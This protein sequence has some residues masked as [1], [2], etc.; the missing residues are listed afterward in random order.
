VPDTGAG[1]SATNRPVFALDLTDLASPASPPNVGLCCRSNPGIP[2][3]LVTQRVR[4]S[5]GG[6]FVL[7]EGL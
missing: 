7:K 3:V 1:R 6:F 5:A 4:S 2:D